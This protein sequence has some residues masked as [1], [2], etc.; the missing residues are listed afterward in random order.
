MISSHFIL[1][2]RKIHLSALFIFLLLFSGCSLVPNNPPK[3]PET[4]Y[5]TSQEI[6]IVQNQKIKFLDTISGVDGTTYWTSTI[7]KIATPSMIGFSWIHTMPEGDTDQGSHTITK[8]DTSRKFDPVLYDR[9]NKV[10]EAT[11]PWISR[12]VFNELKN[13]GV[14]KNFEEGGASAM[15]NLVM[16]DLTVDEGEH[17]YQFTYK[18]KDVVVD[19]LSLNNGMMKVLDNPENPLVLQYS[20]IGIPIVTNVFGWKLKQID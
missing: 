20:P 6:T 2:S 3:T 13:T 9:E 14:S 16:I 11:M 1:L 5:I 15:G 8:F 19:V 4:T 17:T 18:G 12:T 10:T 7:T